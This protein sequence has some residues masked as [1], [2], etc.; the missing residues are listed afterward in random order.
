MGSAGAFLFGGAFFT[1]DVFAGCFFA[2]AFFAEPSQCQR[3]G[4][5]RC[6][7]PTCC[8][9]SCGDRQLT[10]KTQLAGWDHVQRMTALPMV[11]GRP[12]CKR[13]WFCTSSLPWHASSMHVGQTDLHASNQLISHCIS[14]GITHQPWA[15]PWVWPWA[16]P[17]PWSAPWP[18]RR[19]AILSSRNYNAS[20]RQQQGC[21][22]D[23]AAPNRQHGHTFG[24]FGLA[25][26]FAFEVAAIAAQT[27]YLVSDCMQ[28]LYNVG[29][30]VLQHGAQPSSR[31]PY[32]AVC[33]LVQPSPALGCAQTAAPLTYALLMLCTMR[34]HPGQSIVY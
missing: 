3:K 20:S 9:G 34:K 24:V 13:S 16:W 7:C 28:A 14:Q 15:W 26:A 11:L 4:Q 12:L 21:R 17:P 22:Y 30:A 8:P 19:Q 5:A 31:V 1:D 18:A 32:Q 33:D 27:M 10:R 6:W 23:T 2:D 29:W 25:V